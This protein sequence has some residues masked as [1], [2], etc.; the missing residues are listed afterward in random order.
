MVQSCATR[1][2]R[3]LTPSTPPPTKSR[4]PPAA[5]PGYGNSGSSGCGWLATAP[6]VGSRYSTGL[7]PADGPLKSNMLSSDPATLAV[8]PVIGGSVQ[9]SWTNLVIDD[10]SVNAWSTKFDLAKGEIT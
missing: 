4:M 9:L 10:W 6:V 3:R 5:T 2:R 8:D 7:V 1:R